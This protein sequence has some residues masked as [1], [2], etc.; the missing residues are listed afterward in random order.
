[1]IATRILRPRLQHHASRA[2]PICCSSSTSTAVSLGAEHWFLRALEAGAKPWEPSQYAS[3]TYPSLPA[4]YFHE[5][6]RRR[7]EEGKERSFV[8]SFP[9]QRGNW[10]AYVYLPVPETDAIKELCIESMA[11]LEARLARAA[12]R[13]PF[14]RRRTKPK[15]GGVGGGA[16]ATTA[17]SNAADEQRKPQL[18]QRRGDSNNNGS[19]SGGGNSGGI[20]G[21]NGGIGDGDSS[22]GSSSG[23][24]AAPPRLVPSASL[25]NFSGHHHLS[26]SRTAVLQHH[27]I[28]AFAADLG[29]ALNGV[30]RCFGVAGFAWCFR[31]FGGLL[32]FRGLLRSAG[33]LSAV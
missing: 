29:C 18:Q 33:S 22:R 8:R 28:E 17:A 2:W 3:F 6:E 16:A 19:N 23:G 15:R 13:R 11:H 4:A 9:H 30:R 5:N 31:S 21:S 12:G 27:H 7:A 25:A 14:K 26:L 10:P 24:I 32:R 1:M 20:G